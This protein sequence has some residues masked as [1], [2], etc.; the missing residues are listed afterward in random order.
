MYKKNVLI[1]LSAAFMIGCSSK[2]EK[3]VAESL[4]VRTITVNETVE[5]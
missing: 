3:N 5:T 4:P 1:I 2:Q